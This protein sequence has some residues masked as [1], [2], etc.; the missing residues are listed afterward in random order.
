LDD[1]YDELAAALQFPDYF[2]QNWDAVN[3]CLCDLDWVVADA[4]VLVFID[5]EKP[6]ATAGDDAGRTLAKLLVVAAEHWNHGSE[7]SFHVVVHAR[8]TEVDTVL[9]RWKVL[10]LDLKPLT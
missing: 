1:F 9:R 5:G 6:L 8:P 2:G 3:D 7:R 4:I 10:G